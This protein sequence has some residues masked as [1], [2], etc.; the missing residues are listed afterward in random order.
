V[1]QTGSGRRSF[2]SSLVP[3]A[4]TATGTGTSN[5]SRPEKVDVVGSLTVTGLSMLVP[6]LGGFTYAG[7]LMSGLA[8]GAMVVLTG[9][10]L[11]GIRRRD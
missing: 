10:T 3:S 8:G 1:I 2:Q 6:V 5:I 4:P 11:T 9:Y 7:W